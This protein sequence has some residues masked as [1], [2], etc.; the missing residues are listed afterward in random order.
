M[1]NNRQQQCTTVAPPNRRILLHAP[2]LCLLVVSG[3]CL[4]AEGDAEP[5]SASEI[6]GSRSAPDAL[7]P[8]L[9]PT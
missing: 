7:P 1:A 6:A 5:G 9:Q 4:A 2:L 8:N 3:P